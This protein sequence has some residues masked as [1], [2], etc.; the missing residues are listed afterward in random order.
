MLSIAGWSADILFDLGT[1]QTRKRPGI[2]IYFAQSF[3]ILWHDTYIC[4]NNSTKTNQIMKKIAL[5]LG[6]IAFLATASMAQKDATPATKERATRETNTVAP[7]KSN[8]AAKTR[9]EAAKTDASKEATKESCAKSCSDKEK[10]AGCCSSKS[11]KADAKSCSDKGGEKGSCCDKSKTERAEGRTETAPATRE[12]APAT[13]QAAAPATRDA[14][15]PVRVAPARE[16]APAKE[17]Q[18]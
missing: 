13:R 4:V 2:K 6:F 15:T 12:A 5:T 7:V 14:A 11:D 18:N 9:E 1:P 3:V 16:T 17:K 8:D 10:A